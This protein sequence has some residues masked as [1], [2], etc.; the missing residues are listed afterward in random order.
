MSQGDYLTPRRGESERIL[1]RKY[2]RHPL[3]AFSYRFGGVW[4]E[5][6]TPKYPLER[7]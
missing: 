2:A 3:A 7:G 1:I 4:R 5:F 6:L